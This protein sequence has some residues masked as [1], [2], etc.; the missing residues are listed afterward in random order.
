VLIAV[1]FAEAKA[2][3]DRWTGGIGKKRASGKSIPKGR[4]RK[5]GGAS[6]RNRERGGVGGRRREE[7]EPIADVQWS[8]VVARGVPELRDSSD[9]PIGAAIGVAGSRR[10]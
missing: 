7:R 4:K 6:L 2:D 9:R 1:T 8:I 5:R 10:G 3:R